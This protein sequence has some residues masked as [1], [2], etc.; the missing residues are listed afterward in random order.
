MGEYVGAPYN[1]VPFP[2]KV[3]S[4]PST[5][6]VAHDAVG[7]HTKVEDGKA[8]ELLSG[9]IAYT[10]TAETPVFVGAGKDQAQKKG[11][12]RFFRDGYGRFAI[13]GS[14]MRG[15]VRS[16]VQILSHSSVKDDVDDYALMYRQVAGKAQS[17]LKKTYDDI[18][19]NRPDNQSKMSILKNVRAGYMAYKDGQYIIYDTVL[20]YAD[21]SSLGEMNYYVLSERMIQ[22]DLAASKG[23]MQGSFHYGLFFYDGETHHLIHDLEKGFRE[24]TDRRGRKHYKGT[25]RK[26]YKPYA[27]PCSYEVSGTKVIEV[28]ASKNP[29]DQPKRSDGKPFPVYPK[30][31][32]AVGTGKMKEKKAV[33][34]IPEIDKSKSFITVSDE[35]IRAF[36]IDIQKRET[37]LKQFGGREVFDL[38]KDE[39]PKPVFYIQK[40]KRLY[41]G[42]TPRLRLFY[43]HT[44]WDGMPENQAKAEEL[45][46]ARAL[47]GYST[48]QASYKSRVSFSDAVMTEGTGKEKAS[49][50]H[51]ILAEPKPTSYLDYVLPKNGKGQTYNDTRFQIRGIKQYWLHENTEKGVEEEKIDK[52]FV[53]HFIPLEKGTKFTGKIRYENLTMEELGLLLWGL[54]LKEQCQI[55]IGK[56]KAFGF[57]RVSVTIDSVKKLD[58]W[59]A[60]LG[61]DFVFDPW[62]PVD[63]ETAIDAYHAVIKE[64][65]GGIE[66][67]KTKPIQT[68]LLM[69]GAKG[70]PVPKKIRFMRIDDKEYQ[71]RVDPLPF[72]EEV[73]GLKVGRSDASAQTTQKEE[74]SIQVPLQPQKPKTA[75]EKAEG[76]EQGKTY[77]AIVTGI[78]GKKIKFKTISPETYGIFALE[79]I[80]I[81][82][83]TVTK[84]DLKMKI[85]EKT[86]INVRF[87]GI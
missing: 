20:D 69:K 10:L 76:L 72:P 39:K 23:S 68:L 3:L 61:K 15:Q 47:F 64:R 79:E 30:E 36:Q 19:G 43:D 70:L 33:Y 5:A 18:L 74:E 66:T 87:E 7:M 32:Y 41:F 53:T 51:V 24:E 49:A 52:D 50:E 59:K 71:S 38:P 80:M 63:I 6:P 67:E 22:R 13:P 86:K 2:E 57:G 54:R 40:G 9:E 55:N 8:E 45:D 73:L 77:E 75:K 26:G 35:D 48:N 82:G 29:S 31:G 85:A 16:N 25:E 44:I 62:A 84:G 42:F 14:T 78:Q 11:P 28:G 21:K 83:L 1:F 65:L 60:Y 12:E 58:T 37:T 81:E 27:V 46:Y 56:A 34:I 17:S 4:Y